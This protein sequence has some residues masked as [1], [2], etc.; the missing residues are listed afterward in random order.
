M[1]ILSL[2]YLMKLWKEWSVPVNTLQSRGPSNLLSDFAR[3]ISKKSERDCGF[4]IWQR[5]L[6]WVLALLKS[7]ED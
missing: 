5:L 6:G 1:L 2:V 7:T 3:G 4:G